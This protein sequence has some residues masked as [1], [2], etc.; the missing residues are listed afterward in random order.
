[1]NR[2]TPAF[3]ILAVSLTLLCC[4]WQVGESVAAENRGHAAPAN[5]L[6]KELKDVAVRD[7]FIPAGTKAAG[8]IQSAVAHVVVARGDLSQ[9]YYAA[10]GDKLFEQDVVFTLKDSKCRIKLGNDDIITLGD[11]TRLAVKEMTGDRKTSEKKSVLALVR[12]KAMFYA[13]RLFNHKSATMNVVSPTAVTGVRGT[14]FGVEVTLMNETTAAARPLLLADASAGWARHLILAQGG[15]APQATTVVHGFEGTVAVTSTVDGRTQTVGAGQ[16]ISTTPQGIGALIPTPPQVSQSFQAATNVPPPQG[17]SGAGD[18]GGT[19]GGQTQGTTGGTT[20]TATTTTTAAGDAPPP[21]VDTSNVTQTQSTTQTE[22]AATQTDPVTDPK[23]N[24]SGDHTGYFAGILTN[25]STGGFQDVYVSRNRYN[26]D[27]SV[28]GRGLL[29]SL[30]Y[31][32]VEGGGQFGNPI[33]KWVELFGATKSSGLLTVPVS[34]TILGTYKNPTTGQQYLEWGYATMPTFAVSTENYAVDNRAY[35]V[36][37]TST[38]SADLMSLTGAGYYMGEA[39]GTYWNSAGG[40][41]MSGS[42]SCDVNFAN[43]TLTGFHLNV[44]GANASA[45]ITNAT[46]TIGTDAHFQ[47]TGGDWKLNG[48]TPANTNAG[49][50]IYGPSGSFIGGPWGM[51]TDKAAAAGIYKGTKGAQ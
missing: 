34:S 50:S 12:G 23:T 44:S 49:G 14:K 6:P 16:T 8:V 32:R 1:M 17:A 37:G 24:A 3:I 38:L 35:Y 13:I 20:T 2:R 33:L 48:V 39:F 21:V 43:K 51:S 5:L 40:V 46:G 28:W 36:F 15:P 27:G 18:S 7:Y 10:D 4:G 11:N 19:S 41:N 47:L 25:L 31:L 45:S 42:F 26:G 30:D 9:A 29:S 22:Q